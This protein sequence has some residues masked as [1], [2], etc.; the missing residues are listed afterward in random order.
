MITPSLRT[1]VTAI[2]LAALLVLSVA[3]DEDI[4]GVNDPFDAEESFSVKVDATGVLTLDVN[5]I[6]GGIT[7]TGSSTVDSVTI[8]GVKGVNADTQAEA[9]AALGSIDVQIQTVG[10]QIVVTT[11]HPSSGN[12]LNF[13]VNYEI[14][15]PD[16]MDL[17][18]DNAIGGI[19][20]TRIT[21]DVDIDN[22]NGGIELDDI[23]GSVTVDLGNGGI[24]AEITLPTNGQI[25]ITVG[26]GAIV[27]AIPQNT[28]AEF[29][30]NVG[31][32]TI[33]ITGLTLQ[34]QVTTNTSVTGTL[35]AGDGEIQLSTGNG[36]IEVAGF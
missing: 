16:D 30:A 10:D 11:V 9:E 20:V 1:M 22:A 13:T 23:T 4:T 33:S 31:N 29:S 19:L 3:C 21:A 12:G 17:V 7:I 24:A 32:G 26:N 28:S 36:V 27:L 5:G 35:G 18:I 15:V 25:D 34:N 2:P 14:T 6:I 8:A